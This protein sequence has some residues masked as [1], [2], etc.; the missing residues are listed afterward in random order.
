[1]KC[2]DKNKDLQRT[3]KDLQVLVLEDKDF[4]QGHRT[5]VFV[6]SAHFAAKPSASV[7]DYLADFLEQRTLKIRLLVPW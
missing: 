3:Y 2:E 5:V 7:V 6:S 1:M 4:S